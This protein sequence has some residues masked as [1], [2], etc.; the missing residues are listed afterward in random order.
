M[1]ARHL[2]VALRETRHPT[3]S[4][5][6]ALRHGIIWGIVL[7]GVW[8]LGTFG[9]LLDYLGMPVSGLV[10]NELWIMPAVAL[11]AGM[12]AAW[13]STHVATGAA[14]GGW[15]SVENALVVSVTELLSVCLFLPLFV[16]NPALVAKTTQ[17][18]FDPVC[19]F[20]QVSAAGGQFPVVSFP[21][22][23]AEIEAYGV[24]SVVVQS[25][26]LVAVLPLLEMVWA[27]IVGSSVA[28]W[29][30]LPRR[31]GIGARRTREALGPRRPA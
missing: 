25:V 10:S 23:L 14:V 1:L 16:A 15:A 9:G 20:G 28:S 24:G 22:N 11:L 2:F 30:G 4:A 8:L 19:A 6:M 3:P 26:L 7:A 18:P 17:F 5:A 13:K 21:T 12:V 27:T 31:L 29:P